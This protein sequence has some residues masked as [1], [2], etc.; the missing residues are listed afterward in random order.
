[1]TPRLWV[2]AG[3]NGAGKSTIVDHYVDVPIPIINPDNIA[4]TLPPELGDTARRLQSG[5]RAVEDR[6]TLLAS[7]RSFGIE[8]TLTGNSELALMRSAVEAGYQV[9][10]VYVGI[11][12]VSHSI[13]RVRERVSRGGHD[14]PIDDI[15]RRFDRSLTN[16]AIAVQLANHRVLL[17]DNSG[18]RRRLILSSKAGRIK[19]RSPVPPRWAASVM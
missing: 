8:T 12:D 3:P 15:M 10:L 1:M 7:R 9:N 17:I 2:F 18:R 4:R 19:Y 16:L 5:K 13:G 14:V 6:A 11:R